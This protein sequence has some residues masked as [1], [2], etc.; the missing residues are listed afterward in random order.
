M[1]CSLS[2]VLKAACAPSF[3]LQDSLK[4]R[5]DSIRR[6]CKPVPAQL[7]QGKSDR[8]WLLAASC[9]ASHVLL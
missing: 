6:G 1:H 4:G 7:K 2:E 5:A 3:G 9:Q 8:C